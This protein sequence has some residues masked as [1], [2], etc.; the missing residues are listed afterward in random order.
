MDPLLSHSRTSD[1]KWRSLEAEVAERSTCTCWFDADKFPKTVTQDIAT[2]Q[3]LGVFKATAPG[4]AWRAVRT[5]GHSCKGQ[6]IVAQVEVSED[7][8]EK[9]EPAGG[10]DARGLPQGGDHRSVGGQAG[11]ECG[12]RGGA[13]LRA[14]APGSEHRFG[15]GLSKWYAWNARSLFRGGREERRQNMQTL[16]S[17]LRGADIVMVQ[18][19]RAA[20]RVRACGM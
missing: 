9:V 10:S 7:A 14:G 12:G 2:K 20:E 16:A 4:R 15:P 8:P 13:G 19:T 1:G 18:E 3:L 17:L 6:Q 5:K 11:R